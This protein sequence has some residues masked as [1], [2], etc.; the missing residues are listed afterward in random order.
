MNR[1]E[2]LKD[3]YIRR[4]DKDQLK[5]KWGPD[6]GKVRSLAF[7]SLFVILMVIMAPLA[8]W[9]L[10]FFDGGNNRLS[11][12]DIREKRYYDQCMKSLKAEGWRPSDAHDRCTVNAWK[13]LQNYKDSLAFARERNATWEDYGQ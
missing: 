3:I 9:D 12:D 5:E 1:K 4:L 8:M 2:A 6:Y 13:M 7:G 11:A 10:G